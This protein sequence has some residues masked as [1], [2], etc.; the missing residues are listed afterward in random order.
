MPNIS[1]SAVTACTD[2]PVSEEHPTM[3][4]ERAFVYLAIASL[5]AMVA[6]GFDIKSRRIPN[7]LTGP[8]LLAGLLLHLGIDGWHG[9]LTSFAAAMICGGIFLVFYLAGGMGAGDVKLIAAVG[10]IAGLPS[11]P[12]LLVLTSLAGGVLGIGLALMRG[13]LKQ[14]LFNVGALAAH[15][16][17]EGF[18]PHPELNV[19]N[20]GAL[21]LPYG[22]AIAVGCTVTF[23]LQGV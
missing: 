9:L 16:V 22:L 14:T 5:C 12:Y 17:Q 4:I 10:A 18:T 6:A 20:D 19:R 21:R 7:L 8:A 2:C 13:R 15:H 23:C 1:A 3:H 11:T